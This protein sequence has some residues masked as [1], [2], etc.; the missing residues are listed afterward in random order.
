MVFWHACRDIDIVIVFGTFIQADVRA[1]HCGETAGRLVS[2]SK[3]WSW[4]LRAICRGR[5]GLYTAREEPLVLRLK[6]DLVGS[7]I[8]ERSPNCS[9]FTSELPQSRFCVATRFFWKQMK[10]RQASLLP[11][12]SPLENGFQDET[13]TIEQILETC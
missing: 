10:V 5:A 12:K 9:I 13:A 1:I 11:P 3:R 6:R 2:R 7:R 8:R 4:A